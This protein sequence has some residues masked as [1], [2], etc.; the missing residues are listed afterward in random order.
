MSKSKLGIGEMIKLGLVLVCYAVAACAVLAV[1]NNFTSKKIAENEKGNEEEKNELKSAM[2]ESGI[3]NEM[4]NKI[5]L[6]NEYM[7]QA[8]SEKNI[9]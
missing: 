5:D 9:Y 7:G 3:T 6:S 4:Y 8:Y 2:L 1:V